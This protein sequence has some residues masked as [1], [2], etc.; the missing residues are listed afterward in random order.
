MIKPITINLIELEDNG[1]SCYLKGRSYDL[2]ENFQTLDIEK[3]V[4]YYKKGY[5][6]YND[7]LCQYSIAAS[8]NDEM[9]IPFFDDEDKKVPFPKYEELEELSKQDNY[10]G[11]CATFACA[12]YLNYG[13]GIDKDEQLAYNLIKS[14]A[15]RGHVGAMYDL[16][17]VPKFIKNIGEDE[18]QRYLELASLG[19]SMRAKKKYKVR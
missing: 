10:E 14:C 13:I 15:D 1:F 8:L 9:F 12:F 17:T 4:Y 3:A 7:I 19:G 11:I 2:Q 5:Y 18:S 16:G 6:E